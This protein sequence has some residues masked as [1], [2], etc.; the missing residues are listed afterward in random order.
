[1]PTYSTTAEKTS[2]RDEIRVLSDE[3]GSVSC[4]VPAQQG[5]KYGTVRVATDSAA[6]YCMPTVA[7]TERLQVLT[8]LQ[9]ADYNQSHAAA[10]LGVTRQQLRRRIE[11]HFP[12]G[13]PAK[14]GR[15]QSKQRA[16]AA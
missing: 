2:P 14:R 4:Q 6:V 1:M 3:D 10:M 12:D 11:R 7:E 16:K 13:L 9:C 5:G 8:A 15:P